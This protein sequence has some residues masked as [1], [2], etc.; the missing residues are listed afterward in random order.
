MVPSRGESRKS[1]TM[2]NSRYFTE[3]AAP[4]QASPSPPSISPQ[5]GIPLYRDQH[6]TA[7][8]G[9]SPSFVNKPK[10]AEVT[11][12]FAG[13]PILKHEEDQDQGF[14]LLLD[15]LAPVLV[16]D[17]VLKNN[18]FV[19]NQSNFQERDGPMNKEQATR[20]VRRKWAEMGVAEKDVWRN[21]VGKGE[22]EIQAGS[23]S[24]GSRTPKRDKEKEVSRDTVNKGKK[25]EA[26]GQGGK[27]RSVTSGSGSSTPNKGTKLV[28]SV[29]VKRAINEKKTSP[30]SSPRPLINS[31][32]NSESAGNNLSICKKDITDNSTGKTVNKIVATEVG[33]NLKLFRYRCSGL[34][35]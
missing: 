35:V 7:P 1:F 11:S 26:Q 21:L 34:R 3:L 33:F 32:P 30:T 15:Q 16:K 23:A 24:A 31:V 5:P 10:D 9:V 4:S 22:G 20:M 13:G 12:S 27:V 2:A 29:K 17:Y 25:R 28:T 6:K 18:G 8:S 14:L 19:G